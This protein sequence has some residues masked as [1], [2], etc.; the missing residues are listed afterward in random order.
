MS[1]SALRYDVSTISVLW[2]RDMLRFFR[3]PTRIVGALLQ[4]A[5]FWLVVGGGL[6]ASLSFDSPDGTLDYMGF[7]FPGVVLMVLL[8]ASIFSAVGVIEDRHRGFLQGVLAGPG[9]RASV[10]AG[11]MLGASSLALLQALVLTLLAPLAGFQ[12]SAI[13]WPLLFA[14]LSLS[15]L[16][17]T[18]AGIATAWLIDNVQGYHALAMTFMFP[19]WIVSGAMFPPPPGLPSALMLAN[20]LSYASTL[21][22]HAFHGG[23]APAA[24]VLDVGVPVSFAVLLAFFAFAFAAATWVA[25]RQ[26]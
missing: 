12:F 6:T 16:A 25:K 8:F 24:S 3:E 26:R 15:A 23:Q 22:R 18:A 9:S 11:K 20:P 14:C 5:I 4:P 19:L 10:V 13:H 7:F 1:E 2:Q 21:V 17:L